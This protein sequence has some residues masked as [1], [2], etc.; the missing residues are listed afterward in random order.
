VSSARQLLVLALGAAG[1]RHI[2]GEGL[3]TRLDPIAHA[4]RGARAAQLGLGVKNAPAVD[5]LQNESVREA[6]GD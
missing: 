5:A 4:R 3:A 1:A 6:H 2:V